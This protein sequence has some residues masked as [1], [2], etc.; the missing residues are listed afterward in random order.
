MCKLCENE[1]RTNCSLA[2]GVDMNNLYTL[3]SMNNNFNKR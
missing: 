1:S 3:N 2:F